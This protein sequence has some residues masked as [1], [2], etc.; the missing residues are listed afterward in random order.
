MKQITLN[1]RE[2]AVDGLPEVSGNYAVIQSF[3][4]SE[5]V[6]DMHFSEVHKLWNASDHSTR[7]VALAH[8]IGVK[9]EPGNGQIKYWIPRAELSAAFKDGETP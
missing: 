4:I 1:F 7:D 9:T 6:T 3:P 2:V 8:A 5:Q